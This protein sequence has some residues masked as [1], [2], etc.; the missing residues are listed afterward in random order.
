[1]GSENSPRS[2]SLAS[3]AAGETQIPQRNVKQIPWAARREWSVCC[4]QRSFGCRAGGAAGKGGKNGGKRQGVQAGAAAPHSR[5]MNLQFL[6][7]FFLW[8][9][10]L[11][12]LLLSQVKIRL[13]VF[14]KNNISQIRWSQHPE[15][16]LKYVRVLNMFV[17]LCFGFLIILKPHF[18]T[19]F[20]Q[21]S[22]LDAFKCRCSWIFVFSLLWDKRQTAAALRRKWLCKLN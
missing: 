18:W 7:W 16:V 19:F 4:A 2:L 9:L 6:K 20:Y 15:F 13:F 10:F 21:Y 1:M 12:F 5:F 8:R 14:K 11:T 22:S 17:G 3:G